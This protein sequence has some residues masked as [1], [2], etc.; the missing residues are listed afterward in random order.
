MQSGDRHRHDCR[1][2]TGRLFTARVEG[3]ANRVVELSTEL[4]GKIAEQIRAERANLVAAAGPSGSARDEE[5]L[6]AIK[7]SKRPVVALNIHFPNDA[8]QHSATAES[9]LGGLLLKAGF[10]VVDLKA[11]RR[12]DVEITGIIDVSVGRNHG[13]LFRGHGF[14]ELKIQ[15]RRTGTSLPSIARKARRW[16]VRRC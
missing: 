6:R 12:P 16:A 3:P 14:L 7:G 15:E 10:T 4:A 13:G 8:N 11:E 1:Y 5:I 2:Q 9:E